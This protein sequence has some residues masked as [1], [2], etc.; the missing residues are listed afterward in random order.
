MKMNS[1]KCHSLVAGHAFQQ[2]WTKIGADLVWESNSVKLLE[3]TIDK[4]LKLDEDI[5]LLCAKAN[6]K[7]SALV[8]ISYYLKFHQKRTL[9]KAFFEFQ[10]RYCSITSMFRIWKSNNKIN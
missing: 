4:H 8:R 9:T 3:I 7:L 5:S 2:I 10:F 6:R 1:D